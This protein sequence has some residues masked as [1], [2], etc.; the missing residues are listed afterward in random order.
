MGA[1]MFLPCVTPI[2]SS[3]EQTVCLS[4]FPKIKLSL[5]REKIRSHYFGCCW[6]L[7]IQLLCLDTKL[8]DRFTSDNV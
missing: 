8:V 7:V 4:S 2:E 6:Y 3:P 1:G 5:I